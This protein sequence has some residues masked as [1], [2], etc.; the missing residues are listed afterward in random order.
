MKII[1]YLCT[2]KL[3]LY[4]NKMKKVFV[5]L[6]LVA[7]T[8]ALTSCGGGSAT[9]ETATVDSTAVDSTVVETVDSTATVADSATVVDTVSAN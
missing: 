4:K 9:E 2:H 6:S 1:C 5:I 3:N 8:F 7:T